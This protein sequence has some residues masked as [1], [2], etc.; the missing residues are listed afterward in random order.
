MGQCFMTPMS[1][2]VNNKVAPYK[3]NI[4]IKDVDIENFK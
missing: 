1:V 3:E 2:K 4:L